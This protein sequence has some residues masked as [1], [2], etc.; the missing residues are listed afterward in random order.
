MQTRSD[1]EQELL[2]QLMAADNSSLYSASRLTSLIKNAYLW[3]TNLFIW[4]DLVRAKCTSTIAGNDYYDYP[5]EFRSD[6]II[7][8]EIDGEPYDQINYEDFLD[9][10]RDNPNSTEK[11]FANFGR[12]L[13]VFP[14]PTAN[15]A[16]NMDLWGA[17]QADPL[18]N[19]TD[20]PI[21]SGN[22]ESANESV[23]RKGFSVAIKRSD[24]TLSQSEE[25]AAVAELGR[26]NAIEVKGRQRQKRKNKPM[27]NVP[28]FFAQQGSSIGNFYR[29]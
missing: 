8:V 2:S 19:S 1:L 11:L 10:R 16:N 24:S 3:A 6:T 21:F 23:V 13:W 18:V 5:E 28:D 9:F 15:G 20:V 12:Q 26:L 22:K 27:L 25:K 17:I 4:N 14:T 7:R 29:R